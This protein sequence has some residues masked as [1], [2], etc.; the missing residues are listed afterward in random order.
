MLDASPLAEFISATWKAV[1]VPPGAELL[2]QGES[3]G[4]AFLIAVGLAKLSRSNADGRV[5][6]VGLRGRGWLLGFG[7][8]ILDAPSLAT[9]TA[10]TRCRVHP[11]PG[12]ELRACLRSDMRVA[13]GALEMLSREVHE[14]LAD[15]ADFGMLRASARLEQLLWSLTAGEP[16]GGATR[17]TELDLPLRLGE[18]AQLLSV[19]PQYLS[20]LL[21][22]LRSRGVIRG[23][24]S[25]MVVV[26]RGLLRHS[27]DA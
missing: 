20:E 13:F 15:R 18:L 6:I 21:A 27:E 4:G 17:L 16:A 10:L 11:V 8:I 1:D 2:R 5:A 7:S 25:K 26:Q 24:G 22:A 14:Q 9:V 12:G 3:V 19:T 23:A